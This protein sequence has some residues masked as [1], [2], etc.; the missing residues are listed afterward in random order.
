MLAVNK[1]KYTKFQ[2]A[3]RSLDASWRQDRISFEGNDKLFTAMYE[4]EY[5][6]PSEKD[7][8]LVYNISAQKYMLFMQ[9][10]SGCVVNTKD[11]GDVKKYLQ[12]CKLDRFIEEE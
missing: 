3:F 1:E 2:S 8:I 12:Q 7:R 11:I 5:P 6:M 9:S 4:P 10:G